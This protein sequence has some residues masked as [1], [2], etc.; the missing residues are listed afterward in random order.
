MT[1]MLILIAIWAVFLIINFF[2]DHVHDASQKNAHSSKLIKHVS[3]IA[4]LG[5][6]ILTAAIQA[7]E[8]LLAPPDIYP[9][10]YSLPYDS[11]QEIEMTTHGVYGTFQ[12]PFTEIYYTTDGTDP[13]NSDTAVKYTGKFVI[14]ESTCFTAR[15]VVFGLLW[16]DFANPSPYYQIAD[17]GEDFVPVESIEINRTEEVF[18]VGDTAT[19]EVTISPENATDK[20]VYWSSS[21]PEIISIDR[22][23]GAFT[24]HAASSQP[25]TIEACT[26]SGAL[27]ARIEL[28]AQERASGSTQGSA[29]T[30][31][32]PSEGKPQG[33]TNT[34]GTQVSEPP[35]TGTTSPS[36]GQ[37]PLYG[38][39]IIPDIL[40]LNELEEAQLEVLPSPSNATLQL[41][42][43]SDDELIASV[44]ATGKVTAFNAGAT[45]ISVTDQ[46]GISATVLV[47]V[48]SPE[49]E[50]DGIEVDSE[51][52][53]FLEAHGSSVYV[54]AWVT[55][56]NA[57]EQRLRWYS[58]DDD[59]VWVSQDGELFP[60]EV[61]STTIWIEDWDGEYSTA[62][63]VEV[64]DD[65]EG[66]E[67]D[68][69]TFSSGSV[70]VEDSYYLIS[71]CEGV[72]VDIDLSYPEEDAFFTLMYRRVE[73]QGNWYDSD[74]L[75]E[76]PGPNAQSWLS[77]VISA[78]GYDLTPGVYDFLA[79]LWV[80]D[81]D[82]CYHEGAEDYF[83]VEVID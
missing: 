22:L 69:P 50:V 13:S 9:L 43:E 65:T 16:S 79:K 36:D 58:D 1:G 20:K 59:I 27:C 73:D 67:D 5:G 45:Q 29:T 41:A 14:E 42:W 68:P 56:L 40:R 71:M 35:D 74:I 52:P 66:W 51:D 12:I 6:S 63:A 48:D 61:G 2:A 54:D 76:S 44:T 83:Q 62:I 32:R 60:G 72:S 31:T 39:R 55:P 17:K 53:I 11:P 47:L 4:A 33:Q 18:C 19:L 37:I 28:T 77:T 7:G 15:T 57:T 23:T 46:S 49:I 81:T 64:Y 25:V 80:L 75:S 24:V 10:D 26:N 70:D 30:A 82:G 21:A 3:F 38:I 34:S 8:I 78:E